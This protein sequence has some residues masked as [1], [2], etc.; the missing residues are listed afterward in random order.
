M[1][2]LPTDYQD[3]GVTRAL[4]QKWRSTRFGEANPTIM[5]NPVWQWLVKTRHNGYTA[6]KQ[7]GLDFTD[8]PTWSFDRFGQSCTELADGQKVLIAGEHEDF[9]DPDFNIYNDVVLIKTNGSITVFGYPKEV[10]PPTDFHSATLVGSE[11]ILIGSLGYQGERNIGH[12]QVVALDIETFSVR[13]VP[14]SGLSPGWIHR[15]QAALSDDGKAIIVTGGEVDTGARFLSENFDDWALALETGEWRCVAHRPW[16]NW[17]I[18]GGSYRETSDWLPNYLENHE[19][20]QLLPKKDEEYRT[21]RVVL[22]QTVVRF[23]VK[24]S[25]IDVITEGTLPEQIVSDLVE[26]VRQAISLDQDE[27]FVSER[28]R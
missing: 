13:T 3:H 5:T 9:Y 22:D 1:N 23:E 14:T 21:Y 4:F 12:T 6:A 28:Y 11:I 27:T 24:S 25:Y 20:L 19:A 18:I 26:E 8:K 16:A 2:D 17:K 15:H 10:F 7:F